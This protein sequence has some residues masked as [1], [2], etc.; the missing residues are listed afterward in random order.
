MD[1]LERIEIAAD[2]LTRAM[3]HIRGRAVSAQKRLETIDAEMP[4]KVLAVFLGVL[5][6]TDLARLRRER[7]AC[8]EAIADV[9]LVTPAFEKYERRVAYSGPKVRR[10]EPLSGIE[11]LLEGVSK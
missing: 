6:A 9:A 7:A 11:L 3:A 4:E 10:G 1:D 5:D 2:R 8:L